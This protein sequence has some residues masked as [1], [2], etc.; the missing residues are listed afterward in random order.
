MSV[1]IVIIFDI[2][3]S[4]PL[5]HSIAEIFRVH[6]SSFER[7]FRLPVLTSECLFK[8]EHSNRH[9]KRVHRTAMV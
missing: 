6:L 2:S 8:R 7:K 4:N 9:L 1:Y 5:F 3:N